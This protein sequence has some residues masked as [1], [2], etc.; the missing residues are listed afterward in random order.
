[1]MVTTL[2]ILSFHLWHRGRRSRDRMA[3]GFT[4]TC[5][6]NALITKAVSSNHTQGEVYSIQ[7][8]VIKYISVL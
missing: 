6:I 8:Y 7:H 2:H 1:M 5:A 3:V 4:T